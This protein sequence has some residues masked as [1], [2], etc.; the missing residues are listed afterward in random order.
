MKMTENDKKEILEYLGNYKLVSVG[1]YNDLPWAANVFYLFD[2]KFNLYFVSNPKTKHCMNIDKN[3]NVSVTITDSMQDPNGK[4]KGFQGRG[5]ANK[6]SS[7]KE[8]KEIIKA[9][10][11]RGF[12]KLTYKL[13]TKAWKS[14]FYRI[15]LTDIQVFDENQTEDKEE[16]FWNLKK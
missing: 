4:K 16:R 8:L 12:V 10:N 7:V 2:E 11:K 15:K 14:K 13:F 6:V 1:T 5:V 9:W 3:P